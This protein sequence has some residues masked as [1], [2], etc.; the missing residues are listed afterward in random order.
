V[1][2]S[3]GS[4]RWVGLLAVAATTMSVAVACS[5]DEA[6]SDTSTSSS[7]PTSTVPTT[8]A[9]TTVPMGSNVESLSAL[10][11]GLLTTGQIGG[12]WVDQG[13][14]I[15]PPGS[16]QLTGFLCAEG[17]QAIVA[18]GSTMDPQVTTNFRRPNDV[19]LRVFETLM[20]GDREQVTAAF[21]A[22]V[23]AINSCSGKTYT[24]TDLG[25]LTLTVDTTPGLGTSS[26][27]FRFAPAKPQTA[28]PW[29]EQQ[30][31]VVLLSDPNQPV[32]VVLGLG[33]ST[34]H[35]PATANVTDLE[36]SEYQRLVKAAVDRIIEG[37]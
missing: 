2:S 37:L 19:G 14:Q 18:L 17:E 23:A 21:T 15:V 26:I 16:N 29:L 31:T 4:L 8:D 22:F 35:D 12:G 5:D 33:A 30:M 36:E 1:R 3:K 28:N 24:T 13:R 27:A 11:Q 10:I 32:A 7:A 9:T 20:W 6:P 34:V 25:E